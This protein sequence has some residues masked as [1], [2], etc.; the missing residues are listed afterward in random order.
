MHHFGITAQWQTSHHTF[1]DDA[2]F[3]VNARQMRNRL[4]SLFFGYNLNSAHGTFE[5]RMNFSRLTSR[6]LSDYRNRQILA[7]LGLK[8]GLGVGE[9]GLFLSASLDYLTNMSSQIVAPDNFS[10]FMNQSQTVLFNLGLE[11]RFNK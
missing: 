10:K 7:G 8:Y 1:R 9:K 2:M 6:Y 11:W 4:Y 5:P 3:H